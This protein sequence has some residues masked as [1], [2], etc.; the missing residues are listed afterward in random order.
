MNVITINAIY[1]NGVIKPLEPVNLA[2]N[3]QVVLKIVRGQGE[4]AV[5]RK[6]ISLEGIWAGLGD[7]TFEEIEALTEKAYQERLKKLIALLNK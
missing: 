7:P 1:Q 2:E 4:G 6:I 3:E 5:E